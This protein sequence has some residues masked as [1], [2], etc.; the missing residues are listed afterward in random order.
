MLPPNAS[1][2]APHARREGAGI[3]QR[4]A[5]LD[6]VHD[7]LT[8]RDR[9]QRDGGV[10][11]TTFRIHGAKASD[12]VEVVERK[13]VRIEAG[14][15]TDARRG[16]AAVGGPLAFGQVGLRHDDVLDL[17]G[18]IVG[19]CRILLAQDG[20]VDGQP[21]AH[22]RLL[23]RARARREKAS[24]GQNAGAVHGQIDGAET[25]GIEPNRRRG[26]S[27]NRRQLGIDE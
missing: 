27:V 3:G 15:A 1:E 13:T 11:R 12:D 18:Q 6:R 22:H 10:D 2:L 17:G 21:S 7:Q 8:A 20:V 24:V 4:L 9:R 25:V 19:E 14:V 26:H 23:I 5:H 16:A